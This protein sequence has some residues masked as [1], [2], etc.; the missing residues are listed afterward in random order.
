MLAGDV[1][2]STEIMDQHL[3][4]FCR[5]RLA[6]PKSTLDRQEPPPQ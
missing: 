1:I 5:A 3:E 6:A 4:R 2:R